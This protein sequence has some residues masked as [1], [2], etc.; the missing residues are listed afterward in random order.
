MR[1]SYSIIFVHG[2]GSNPDTTWKAKR[3]GTSPETSDNKDYVC[4]VTDFLPQDIRPEILQTLRVFFYNHDSFWQRDAA[5]TRLSNLGYNLLNLM[6]TEIR[7]T[8]EV[9]EIAVLI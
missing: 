9:V 1:V 7:K 2:L 4:W 5:Q 6:S 8:E 3:S